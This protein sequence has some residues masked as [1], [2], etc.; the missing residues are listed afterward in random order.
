[1]KDVLA[2]KEQQDNLVQAWRA[3][4]ESAETVGQGRAIVVFTV[5]TIIFLPLSFLASV[6]GMNASE[7]SSDNNLSLVDE[8]KYMCASGVPF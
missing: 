5:V 3:Q 6:F 2:L 4:V 8:F 1:M 7:L